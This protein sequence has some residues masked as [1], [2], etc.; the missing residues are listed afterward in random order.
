VIDPLGVAILRGVVP[1]DADRI[2][3]GQRLAQTPGVSQV[4][5]RLTVGP[6]AAAVA[7]GPRRVLGDVPPPPPTPSNVRPRRD[8]TEPAG[9]PIRTQADPANPAP[10]PVPALAPV[11]APA[12]APR[13]EVPNRSQP[14]VVDPSVPDRADLADWPIRITVRDGVASIT[15]SVPG[16]YEAMLAYR[17][18]Q[19]TPGV[20]SIVDSLRFTVPDGSAPNPLLAKA[21]PEDAEPYL[22]AQI[23]RQVGDT[24]RIE[25]VK[26]QGDQ[27]LVQ[28]TV[29]QADDRPRVEAILRSM[30]ILRGFK[31]LPELRSPQ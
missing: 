28:G 30:P 25:R 10:A 21:R 1:T 16:V 6:V 12:P 20:A 22:E 7:T 15:G 29:P 13:S 17:A 31:I 9:M 19:R 2:A 18:V 3:I 14:G 11:P 4:I 27:L 26:L 24:A 23:R 8:P 5:N